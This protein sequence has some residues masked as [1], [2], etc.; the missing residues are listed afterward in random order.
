MEYQRDL[1]N[2]AKLYSFPL[3][4]SEADKYKIEV[5]GENCSI[6]RKFYIGEK[7]KTKKEKKLLSKAFFRL[8]FVSGAIILLF[9]FII[10]FPIKFINLDYIDDWIYGKNID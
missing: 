1:E 6:K 9:L 7:Y 3:N 4:I 5:K 10:V 8:L 2:G